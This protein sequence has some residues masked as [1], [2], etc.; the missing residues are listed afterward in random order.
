MD[1]T[2]IAKKLKNKKVLVTGGGGFIG[3]ALTKALVD[4]GA[5]VTVFELHPPKSVPAKVKVIQ[6]DITSPSAIDEATA[7]MDYVFHLAAILGVEKILNIPGKVLKVNLGGT[8]NALEAATK[9]HVK[10]FL[11]TS[12]S[13]IYGEPR[14]VPI[15]ENDAT[16][17]V[18]T[19]GIAK[20]TAEEYCHVYYREYG[21]P[22]TRVRYFNV[23]G[24]G[25]SEKFVVPIF[26]DQVTNNKAP[27]I[28][29]DGK[30]Y[31]C[32]THVNDAVRGTILAAIS[33]ES[34][35]EVFN[36]GND[37]PLTIKGLA[38]YI[39]KLSGKKMKPVYKKFGEGI[40]LERREVKKR[41]PDISKAR[42]IL[43]YNPQ[44]HWKQGI[45]EFYEWHQQD[46][47]L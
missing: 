46:S 23:Y 9:H 5:Q 8:I 43:G 13:E 12:S 22:T 35:D 19:Y 31:R 26:I 36:I 34:V 10:R 37:D 40:R 32:Y 33:E 18:S 45:K 3:T 21:L 7:G 47:R 39:I 25:Q 4:F 2:Q 30:Q 14:K 42:K 1:S 44:V 16:A 38:D 27:T 11:L 29:G 41:M 15:S 6:G 28:Y 24:P 20:L 17:P